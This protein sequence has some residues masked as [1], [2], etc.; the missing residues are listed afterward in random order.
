MTL[1]QIKEV[2]K[3]GK[4]GLIPGWVGYIKYNYLTNQIYLENGDYKMYNLEDQIK[5]R[6][7]LYYII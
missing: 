7:D 2:C 4:I 6:T 1:N 5:D 3:Q